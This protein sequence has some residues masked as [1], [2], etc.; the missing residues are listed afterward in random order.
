MNVALGIEY[1]G[2]SFYGWQKQS[3]DLRTVQAT[4]ENA[5]SQ[6]ADQKITVICAGRTDA[7]V[8]ALGQVVHFTTTADR[9]LNAWLFGGNSILPPDIRIV[10]ANQVREDFSA[11]FSAIARTY[12]YVILNQRF[13]SAILRGL[14]MWEAQAL[15]AH[16]MHEAGQLLLGEHDFSAFRSSECQSKS[17]FRRIELLTVVRE[18]DFVKVTIKANAFLH[19]MVRNIVGVLLEVGKGKQPI[20]WVSSVLKGNAEGGSK[21]VPPDGLYLMKVDYADGIFANQW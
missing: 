2:T 9:P 7:G 13:H 11:R 21:M 6:I 14:V 17:P 8:H 1:C 4:L 18:E 16:D 20:N 3:Q 19:H 15:N 10:W 12:Q 5:L